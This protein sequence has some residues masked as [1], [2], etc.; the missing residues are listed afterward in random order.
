MFFCTVCCVDARSPQSPQIS[1][2]YWQQ[3][4][5]LHRA[6]GWR[7][8]CCNPNPQ[9]RTRIGEIPGVICRLSFIVCLLALHTYVSTYI[10]IHIY[11]YIYIHTHMSFN[12][13]ICVASTAVFPVCVARLRLGGGGSSLHAKHPRT[14][15]HLNTTVFLDNALL[16]LD[17]K[18][19]LSNKQAAF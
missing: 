15:L 5:S 13:C 16:F 3:L 17:V 12:S 6:G 7:S 10:C 2:V 4:G 14:Y 18:A 19:A 8:I 1:A 9:G 11:I